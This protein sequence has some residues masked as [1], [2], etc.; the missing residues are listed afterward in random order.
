MNRIS[1]TKLVKL[2]ENASVGAVG[3]GAIASTAMPLGQKKR[4]K[5]KI[6][7]LKRKKSNLEEASKI[8]YL[9]HATFTKKVPS[10]MKQGLRQFETS[11][12]VEAGTGKRYNEEAGIF[13]FEHPEDAFKWAFKMEWEFKED[14]SIVRI[15][16]SDVWEQDPSGDI[17]LQI[18]KGRSLRSLRNI[19]AS[20]IIDVFPM[21]EFGVPMDRGISA[22][23]WIEDS[24]RKMMSEARVVAPDIAARIIAKE[25]LSKWKEWEETGF[26]PKKGFMLHSYRVNGWY[27]PKTPPVPEKDWI[28]DLLWNVSEWHDKLKPCSRKNATYVSASGVSGLFRPVED[29]VVVG[30]VNWT[31]EQIEQAKKDWNHRVAHER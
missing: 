28:A 31:T 6:P 26:D 20:D 13:A 2:H 29:V 19:P 15:K 8:P 25:D 18:G 9:Y 16:L 3:A 23:E 27:C 11:N 10:I 22:D 1:F 7:A 21:K 14:A 4:K 30:K 5:K 24:A 12:W 17:N